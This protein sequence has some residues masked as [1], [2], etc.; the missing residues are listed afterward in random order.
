MAAGSGGLE[1]ALAAAVTIE[2][3]DIEDLEARMPVLE[4]T[5]PDVFTMYSHLLTAS[6]QH[7]AAFGRQ[8]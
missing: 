7:L 1:Q 5:A 2:Q 4:Q 6:R 8:S 3:T